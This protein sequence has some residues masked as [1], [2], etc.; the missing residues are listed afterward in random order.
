MSTTEPLQEQQPP[1]RVISRGEASGPYQAFPDACRLR[2][3]D[4]MAVFYGGYG[5]VSLPNAE[6]P[7]G[8]RVCLVRSSDEGRTWTAPRVLYDGEHDNRD[9]HIAQLSDGTLICTYFDYWKDG[10]ATRYR[11]MA[12]RS[13]DGGETWETTGQ[14]VSPEM[15]AV[16][17]PVRELPDG[18]LLLGVYREDGGH[19]YGGVVRSTDGGEDLGRADP[20]RPRGEAAAGRRDRRD[21][22]ARRVALRGPSQQPG[23]HALLPLLR[24]RPHLEPRGGYRLPGSRAALHAPEQRRDTHDPSS[25]GDGA[26]CEPRRVPR[27]GRGPYAIDSVGGAYPATVELKDKT[28]L[29]IYYEEGEGERDPRLAVQA[30][31]GRD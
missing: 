25:P 18:T 28:V 11:S 26:A 13:T 10:Q 21:P 6:W 8:G 17:A 12:V 7:R 16:S 27:P 30:E 3:G 4:I 9:P 5:H 24:R 31:G 19:A 23:E 20:D 14:P 22:P 15:W 2:N 29:A 1:F